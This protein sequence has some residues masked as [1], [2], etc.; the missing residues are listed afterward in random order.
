[1]ILSDYKQRLLP[2]QL[3]IGFTNMYTLNVN[4]MKTWSNVRVQLT[5][6]NELRK[7]LII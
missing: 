6:L 7:K 4:T 2:I 1:M 3:E 5:P